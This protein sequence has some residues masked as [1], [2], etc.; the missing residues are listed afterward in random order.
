LITTILPVYIR[1]EGD[2]YHL[3]RALDSI[4]L[5]VQ[6]PGIVIVSDDSNHEGHIEK[7]KLLL[8]EVALTI[9][10]IKNPGTNNAS[11]NTN[12]GVQNATSEIIHILHQDD[13]LVNPRYYQ[14]IQEA[15][16]MKGFSW[17][18]AKGVTSESQNIP[19]IKPELIFGFNSIGGPSALAMKR[20]FWID[21]NSHFLLLPD[22]VQFAQ[23]N[24]NLGPPYVTSSVCVEYGTGD[25]KMTHRITRKEISQDIS[26]LFSL[27]LVEKIP[28][29][30]FLSDHK[31]WGSHLENVSECILKDRN[32]RIG[33]RLQAQIL[34][35]VCRVYLSLV[36]IKVSISYAVSK[37]HKHN[38]L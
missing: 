32:L 21:L 20:E 23:L 37:F 22:V 12:F 2:L 27:E 17:T 28:F 11:E 30:A 4:V 5:Q 9:K 38:H 26:N 16:L 13:W 1:D 7:L 31:Y 15:I 10:Y 34:N 35:R 18:L 24:E 14:E 19:E 8:N 25:H 33:V 6:K 36:K 29:K 3:R